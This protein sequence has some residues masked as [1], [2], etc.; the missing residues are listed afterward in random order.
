[1]SKE[2]STIDCAGMMTVL[3]GNVYSFVFG[4]QQKNSFPFN[5]LF[6]DA[7][8]NPLYPYRKSMTKYEYVYPIKMKAILKFL[9]IV[10]LEFILNILENNIKIILV[11]QKNSLT[12][13]ETF[14]DRVE[15]FFCR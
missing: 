11:T 7:A 2:L 13:L 4:Q 12:A 15:E 8:I 5:S 1:M 6:A 10:L 9:R 14:K 3:T